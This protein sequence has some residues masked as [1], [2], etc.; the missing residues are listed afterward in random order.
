MKNKLLVLIG[1]VLINV[2][3]LEAQHV[4][5]VEQKFHEHSTPE[6]LFGSRSETPTAVAVDV[7]HAQIR[8]DAEPGNRVIWGDV[9]LQYKLKREI[10]TLWL[11]FDNNSLMRVTTVQDDFNQ[12][13]NYY[14]SGNFLVI[15]L[16]GKQDTSSIHRIRIR[17]N[18][19]P[20]GSDIFNYFRSDST[21]VWTR[22]E[23]YGARYW[24]PCIMTL[25]DKIDSVDII[26]SHSKNVTGVANGLLETVDSSRS[27]AITHWKHRYPV[28]Y[29]LIAW[30]IGKYE[31][32][33]Q[34]LSWK[35]KSIKVENYLF[36]N[37]VFWVDSVEDQLVE[38][39]SL[40]D[41]LFGEYPFKEEHYGHVQTS[42]GGGMEHQT[43]SHMRDLN[44]PLVAHELAHQ[45]FGNKVTCGSWED[46]WLNES[47]ATY[48]T[49]L[50][51]EA[52]FGDQEW[53]EWKRNTSRYI[54]GVNTGSVFPVDTNKFGILFNYRLT[55]NKGAYVLHTLRHQIGDK[56]F[57]EGVNNFLHDPKLSYDFAKTKDLRQHL[58]VTS[59]RNL[60]EFFD[61]WYL[62]E[63]HPNFDLYYYLNGDELFFEI[64]QNGSA[65][66]S[67]FF[68]IDLPIGVYKNGKRIDTTFTINKPTE[69]YSMSFKEIPDSVVIDPEYNVLIGE[70]NVT[71]EEHVNVGIA[72][73]LDNQIGV[74]LFPNPVNDILNVRLQTSSVEPVL[75]SINTIT[76]SVVQS[77]E[78]VKNNQVIH[79]PDVEPGVYLI[80]FKYMGLT[81]VK[82]IIKN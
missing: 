3:S 53:M 7:I 16:T 6:N 45:W 41:S 40:F 13:S 38:T 2:L 22:A 46:L 20:M 35:N 52:G 29:Y 31:H 79:L 8:I 4:I 82:R 42:M 28:A 75:Y 18:G 63:G 27:T 39:F 21:H 54:T 56:A 71:E 70:R 44:Q 49:A 72:N 64:Y 47:F 80:E 33:T 14:R 55:Y 32:V 76:G 36:E 68:N 65:T 73:E 5:N 59:K 78:L 61:D 57:F 10:D 15:P 34:N 30:S 24:W 48:L 25:Q 58:E 77:G 1:I 67:P 9:T 23:P 26:L 51:Y 12:N 60:S 69:V 43:M 66:N 37:Q 17:Y 50:T 62:G 11:D 81:Q 74:V 19:E